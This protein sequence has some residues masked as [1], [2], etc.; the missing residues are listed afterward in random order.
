MKGCMEAKPSQPDLCLAR[1]RAGNYPDWRYARVGQLLVSGRRPDALDDAETKAIWRWCRLSS[2]RASADP[3]LSAAYEIYWQNGPLR[4]Q[5]EALA[6]NGTAIDQV[7][8]Q[9]GVTRAVA[10]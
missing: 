6:L 10:G 8:K 5:L 2:G 4:W 3:A 9:T 1:W 7:L